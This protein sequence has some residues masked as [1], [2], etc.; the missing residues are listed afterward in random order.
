[1]ERR[2]FLKL[3][4]LGVT[5]TMAPAI[6]RSEMPTYRNR[7]ELRIYSDY[8]HMVDG[9]SVYSIYFMDEEGNTPPMLRAREGE[10]IEVRIINGDSR[11]HGFAITGI[12]TATVAAIA[13]GGHDTAYF[14]APVG[15]SYL[16]HDPVN[17][18]VNRLL[19]LFGGFIVAPTNGKTLNNSPTPY[20]HASQTPQIR[21]LFD[22]LGQHRRFPGNKWDATDAARDKVWI[23]SQICPDLCERVERREDVTAASCLATFAPRYFLING[24]SGINTADHDEI[25]DPEHKA[26]RAIMIKGRQGQP[27][28]IRT[29]NAGLC[30]HS[31]HI[32]GNSVFDLTRQDRD[33]VTCSDNIYEV[34]AW[35]MAPMARKDMLLPL[36]RPPDIAGRWPPTQEPFPLRYVMHCH[37]EMSTTAGGGNY[38]QGLVTHWEMTGPLSQ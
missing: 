23:F 3:G 36:E 28:L 27:T 4:A 35:T 24:L 21:A 26:A 11:P 14:T 12:P 15:G 18:P 6:A 38:P 1:M 34:D 37:T 31:P 30:T 32:H 17:A 9:Q 16:F 19:G 29:M 10:T 5:A 33:Q 20:S 7:F 8:A 13:P 25:E 22:A 2:Q